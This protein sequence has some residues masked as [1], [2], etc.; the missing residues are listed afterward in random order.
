[1]MEEK[2]SIQ[3]RQQE[4]HRT[5]IHRIVTQATTVHRNNNSSSVNS[6]NSNRVTEF[7]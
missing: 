2:Y 7:R 3:L 6:N 4:M 5:I 1:M